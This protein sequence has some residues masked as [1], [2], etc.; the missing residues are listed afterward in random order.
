MPEPLLD[1]STL[2][3][4]RPTIRIDNVNYQMHVMADFGAVD[5]FHVRRL[6]RSALKIQQMG[7]DEYT[8]ADAEE[9]ST[10]LSMQVGMVIIDLPDDVLAKLTDPMKG[11]ILEVFSGTAAAAEKA[12]AGEASR[13]TGEKSPPDF[14]DSTAETPSDGST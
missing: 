12:E 1:L 8:L 4:T 11:S 13:Q 3:P 14:N 9:F 5:L 10:N 2:A 6:G 7:D